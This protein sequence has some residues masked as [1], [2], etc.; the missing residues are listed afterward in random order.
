MHHVNLLLLD[1]HS[2]Q[3]FVG[4]KFI[5]LLIPSMSTI[6]FS[7]AL[8]VYC[9]S[10][11]EIF[12]NFRESELPL[13]TQKHLA[14]IIYALHKSHVDLQKAAK[15]P[16]RNSLETNFQSAATA[17]RVHSLSLNVVKIII[18]LAF[19]AL[20]KRVSGDPESPC[21][22][23]FDGPLACRMLC[24]LAFPC[25]SL[26]LVFQKLIYTERCAIIIHYSQ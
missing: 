4:A 14:I 7:S 11:R 26:L 5:H 6:L 12:F 20:V 3:F 16:H 17:L 18:S 10:S 8:A 15:N 21:L 25:C 19:A 2:Q 13:H 24:E 1:T 23:P 9:E 22:T